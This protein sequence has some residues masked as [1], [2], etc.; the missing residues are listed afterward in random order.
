MEILHFNIDRLGI[1]ENDFIWFALFSRLMEAA[2]REG[3]TA[4][5]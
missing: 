5:T 3:N 1:Y 2:K 4:V